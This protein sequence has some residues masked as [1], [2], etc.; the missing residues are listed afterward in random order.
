MLLK[1]ILDDS[2]V[3]IL[4]CERDSGSL[5]FIKVSRKVTKCDPVIY[6]FILVYRE[7]SCCA[8]VG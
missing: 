3:K 2:A 4:E 1:G 8:V 5:A 7:N 6:V